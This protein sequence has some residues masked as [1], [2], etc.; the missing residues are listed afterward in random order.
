MEIP[1]FSKFMLII[2]GVFAIVAILIWIAFLRTSGVDIKSFYPK[3][4][5]VDTPVH[6]GGIKSILFFYSLLERRKEILPSSPKYQYHV[7]FF[8]VV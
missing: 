6:L 2:A 4:S 5:L 8:L 1:I 3:T 7:W